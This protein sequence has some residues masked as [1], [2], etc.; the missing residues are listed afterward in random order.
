MTFDLNAIRNDVRAKARTDTDVCWAFNSHP[1]VRA[2]AMTI[3]ERADKLA[4]V[5]NIKRNNALIETRIYFNS[6]GNRHAA[7]QN[8]KHDIAGRADGGPVGSETDLIDF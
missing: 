2:R 3:G 1:L 6:R 8:V 5:F 4:L 7:K